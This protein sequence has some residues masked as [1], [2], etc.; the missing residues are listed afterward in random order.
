MKKLLMLL[1]M[2]LPFALIAQE[3]TDWKE[4]KFEITSGS[5]STHIFKFH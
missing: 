2:A 4:Q 3:K 5:G 1:M